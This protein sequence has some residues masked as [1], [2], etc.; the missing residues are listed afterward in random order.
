MVALILALDFFFLVSILYLHEL[1]WSD[2]SQPFAA[3]SFFSS[4]NNSNKSEGDSFTVL[5]I[6][7]LVGGFLYLIMM[8]CLLKKAWRG[9]LGVDS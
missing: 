1:G 2:A 8:T 3:L 4:V 5:F 7:T 9:L 6:L